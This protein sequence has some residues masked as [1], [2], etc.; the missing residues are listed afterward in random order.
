M[1]IHIY[2][3]FTIIHITLLLIYLYLVILNVSKT[4]WFKIYSKNSSIPLY[5]YYN[6][7]NNENLKFYKSTECFINNNP[8]NS[9]GNIDSN[10]INRNVSTNT[11]FSTVFDKTNLQ[12]NNDTIINELLNIF[13]VTFNEDYKFKLI[14]II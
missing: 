2:R 6:I 1:I 8:I 3:I 7:P 12:V 13:D 5:L 9:I 11:L 4:M 14:N 10:Q